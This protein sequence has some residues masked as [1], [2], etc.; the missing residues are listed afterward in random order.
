MDKRYASL[1]VDTAAVEDNSIL[2]A[3]T[4][5]YRL[6][7]VD[8]DPGILAALRRVFQ[9]ENY[10]LLFA[11]SAEEALTL[12]ENAP[13]ELVVSDFMMSGMNGS[14]FLRRVRE[15]WPE[16]LRI[17]LT[18]Y[19]ST[20]AVMGSM[21]DGA[22]YRFNLKPW[23]DDD[24]R[25]T[26]ALA[27]EQYELRRRNRILTQE[28]SERTIDLTP[29]HDLD[30][31]KRSQLAMLLYRKGLLNARQIQQLYKEMRAHKMPVMH[32]LLQHD[33]VDLQSVYALLR[34]ERMCEEIDLREVQIDPV[35]LTI[36]PQAV[37][38]RQWVIPLRV[39]GQRLDLAMTD[40]LDIGLIEVL[41][42]MS[43][44]DIRPLLCDVGQ[45]QTKLAETLGQPSH[46]FE[47]LTATTGNNDPY[48]SIEIILDEN[49]HAE[50]LE[51]LLSNSAAPPAIRLVNAIILEALRLGA[52]AI[53]IHPRTKKVTVRYRLDGVLQDKIQI[54]TSLLGSVVSRIKV[55]AELDIVEQ[56]QPQEG[57]ITVKT[58]MRIV[59]L[60][61]TTLPTVHGEKIVIHVLDRQ[62]TMR[63]LEELSLSLHNV[64]RLL[65]ANKQP[66]GIILAAG[67]ADSG[68]ITML[69]TLMQHEASI[70][71]D[72]VVIDDQV[73]FHADLAG[74]VPVQERNGPGLASI[75]QATLRQDPD[76]ILLREI[77]DAKVAEAAFHAASS[78]RMVLS[79]LPAQSMAAAFA[80]LIDL[81][82]KPYGLASTLQAIIVLRLARRLCLHCREEVT[83]SIEQVKLLGPNFLDPKIS[84]YR[85]RGCHHC[86]QGY[87]GRIGLQEV[88]LMDDMLRNAI[89]QNSSPWQLEELARKRGMITMLDDARDKLHQGMTSIE[90][91]LRLL[92]PQVLGD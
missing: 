8:D 12:L 69:Y 50:S 24:L 25:L 31:G 77:R 66:Q 37:C 43:G 18:G 54:P 14:E 76:V 53:H 4:M 27:L 38:V 84:I 79:T 46:Q 28:S 63:S 32:H 73:S 72:Y 81:G 33:W 62:A 26:V 9:R 40:P 87:K 65:H 61:I 71:K 89:T 55:M 80:R 44:Y 60:R 41:G 58:P 21:K 74:Q 16:T 70:E 92:G 67:P 86:H 36:I 35:L 13:V 83:P 56:R 5:P 29:L 3:P 48:E 2:A 11:H 91:I 7:L 30:V 15:Q 34:D 88:L 51:Q 45:M 17:M 90:E 39:V 49:N 1:F 82:I 42:V 6:L 10:Q 19:A 68:K 52:S 23:D 78:G 75:F 20:E 22:V 57:Q 64:Q 85:G 47:E 59:D